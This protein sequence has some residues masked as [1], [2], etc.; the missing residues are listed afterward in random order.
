M[1]VLTCA[2]A[3]PIAHATGTVTIRDDDP[4]SLGRLAIGDVSVFEGDVTNNP[5]RFTVSL[6]APLSNDVTARY[7]SVGTSAS[8]GSDFLSRSRTFRIRAGRTSAVVTFK[9]IGDTEVEGTEQFALLLS[10]VVGA[11]CR[12]CHRDRDGVRR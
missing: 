9:S 7:T 10:S 8:T 4:Q 12:R 3:V 5:M 2:D 6:D 11:E 1:V